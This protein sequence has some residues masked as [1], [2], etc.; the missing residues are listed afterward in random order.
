MPRLI[1]KAASK[2]CSWPHACWD[3][4]LKRCCLAG[5]SADMPTTCC[6]RSCAGAFWPSTTGEPHHL[7]AIFNSTIRLVSATC[8]ANSTAFSV[9]ALHQVGGVMW[10]GC[11]TLSLIVFSQLQIALAGNYCHEWA[12]WSAGQAAL[13]PRLPT[14]A[15]MNG[16][17]SL[18]PFQVLGRNDTIT[19]L[20]DQTFLVGQRINGSFAVR[21][22]PTGD[23][24]VAAE[25]GACCS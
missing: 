12:P 3:G 7:M 17:P 4:L 1:Q 8:G 19:Q 21:I 24:G 10:P 16:P 22:L 9:A 13:P 5:A 15:S 11:L 18:A 25:P 6:R 23:A 20:D 14:P 2:G